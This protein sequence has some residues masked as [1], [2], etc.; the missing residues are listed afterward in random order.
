MGIESA[1]K[2]VGILTKNP[3]IGFPNSVDPILQ[4]VIV[5]IVYQLVYVETARILLLL[6][7]FLVL[8]LSLRPYDLV[9]K[10]MGICHLIH[11]VLAAI[12]DELL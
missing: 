3:A 9:A 6:L 1:S 2:L 10:P 11:F 12:I 8:Y 5:D 7:V 4:L